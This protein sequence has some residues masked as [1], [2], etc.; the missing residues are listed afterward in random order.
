[1]S[2][3]LE[4]LR[5]FSPLCKKEGYITFDGVFY[6]TGECK[7]YAKA[8]NVIE[9]ELKA[10]QFV[11][12]KLRI[13]LREIHYKDGSIKYQLCYG[14]FYSVEISKEEYDLLKEVLL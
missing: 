11:F 9:K 5:Q 12:E 6:P 2:K 14:L 3:G 10:K 4:A 13:K 8:Y 7:E 1:M